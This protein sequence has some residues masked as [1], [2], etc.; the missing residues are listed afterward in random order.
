MTAIAALAGLSRE[1]AI[2]QRATARAGGRMQVA[3]SGTDAARAHW[4]A[5][6]LT[7]G[8]PD[9]LVSFGFAGGLD[10]GLAAGTLLVADGVLLPNGGRIPA[11]PAWTARL[12][13]G[14]SGAVA[15]DVRAVDAPILHAADKRTLAEVTGAAAIDMESHALAKAAADAGVPFV[16]IRAIC[17]PAR[18]SVPPAFLALHD[19]GGRL[20][21]SRLQRVLARPGSALLLWRESH[22]AEAALARAARVLAGL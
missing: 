16:V 13:E 19:E 20:R 17:D 14:L 15:G 10:P 1:A 12:R 11:D 5:G 2:L 7:R 9:L 4:E 8:A 18:R 6:H 3:V 22:R 21:W